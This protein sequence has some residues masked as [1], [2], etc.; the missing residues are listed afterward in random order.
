[1]QKIKAIILILLIAGCATQRYGRQIELSP[2][3]KREFTC[4]DIKIEMAK[5]QEFLDSVRMQRHDTNGAHVLG[6][7][8]DFGIGNVMEGD[9]AELS[10]E[11]RLKELR[12]LQMEKNCTSEDARD[13]DDD[14]H[15][16]DDIDNRN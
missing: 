7:L 13:K 9:A 11:K 5:A 8:G 16:K 3:E 15:D 2:T 4:H 14:T 1:M 10:G 12:E 6:F